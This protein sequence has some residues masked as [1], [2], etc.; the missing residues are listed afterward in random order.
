M[1]YVWGRGQVHTGFGGE[2]CLR[3][4]QATWSCECDY[5]HTGSTKCRKFL[6]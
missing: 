5:E 3:I 4:G 2:A 6:D 1:W